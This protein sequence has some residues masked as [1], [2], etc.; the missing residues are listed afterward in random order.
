MRLITPPGVFRPRSDSWLLAEALRGE[1]RPGASVLDLCTGSGLLA[2]IAARQ[3]AGRVVAVDISRRALATARLNA[4]LNHV[5]IEVR[6][7][8]LF[9]PIGDERFDL[10]VSNPPYLPAESVP[11]RG[12]SRAW[13]AGR[14]GRTHL[15]RICEAASDHLYTGGKLVAIQSSVSGIEETVARLS[16]GVLEVEVVTRHR[17]PLGE[18]LRERAA[19]LEARGLLDA[20]AREEEL[21]I[22]RA[23]LPLTGAGHGRL[24]ARGTG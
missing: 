5:R 24:A 21:V 17:G 20:G 15:N 14:D 6:R 18:L 22:I 1:V 8:D 9:D 23:R 4:A 3:G 16:E 11:R 10:I 19:M 13:D 12:A 7:G 2:V